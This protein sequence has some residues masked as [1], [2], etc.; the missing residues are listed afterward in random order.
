MK[1]EKK[2]EKLEKLEIQI[3]SDL[4]KN[5]PPLKINKKD[6]TIVRDLA[7]KVKEISQQQEN[8]EK[9]KLWKDHNSLKRT[10][11]LVLALP[12]NAWGE[13]IPYSVLKSTDP[14]IKE[15]EWYLR[16]LIYHWEELKDDYV[17]TSR[18]KVPVVFTITGWG[19]SENIENPQDENG[20]VHVKRQILEEKDIEKLKFPEIIYD[21]KQSLKNLDFVKEVFGDILN[22]ELYFTMVPN[23]LHA[24]MMGL[25]ARIR[26]LDQILFD[27]I[28]R[29]KW[30]HQV[31]QFLTDGTLAL[32]KDAES[33]GL[34]GL[35]NSD[36][37]FVAGGIG[38][39]DEL[40]QKDFQGK[41]KLRDLWAFAEGQELTGVSPA[42]MDEF[43]I[44]Y[45]IKVLENYGLNYYGCCEDLSNKLQI[46]KKIPNLRRVTVGPWT[47]M[48]KAVDE[49]EDKYVYV[50]KPKASDLA[51]D[52]FDEEMIRE[53]IKRGFGIAKDCIVEII[54]RTVITL[55]DDPGR[56]KKW[57]MIAK[58]LSYN[59]D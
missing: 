6:L 24:G 40:P 27:M 45:Q 19:I 37:F 30:V 22:V 4:S 53:K 35:N 8:I 2:S 43:L 34:L 51:G 28:D 10:R 41:V 50:W 14:F 42:M 38:Y 7:K 1:I 59:S 21:E 25:L 55:R 54:M 39:T 57:S 29:P 5:N 9:I 3:L 11:P 12:E 13:I 23:Y 17:I 47:D 32:I 16:S 56:I 15:Y 31:M 48:N 58:E 49:L 46:V 36:D 33:Q 26:G 20:A 44:P 52:S 18:L